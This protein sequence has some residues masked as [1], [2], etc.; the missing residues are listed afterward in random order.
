[1]GPWLRWLE[2]HKPLWDFLTAVGTVGLAAVT[3]WLAN[4]EAHKAQLSV[5]LRI[6]IGPGAKEPFPEY[7][8]FRIVNNG[9]LP[10]RITQI[11]WRWGLRKKLA[12]VQMYEPTLSSPLPANLGHGEEAQWFVPTQWRAEDPWPKYF[13]KALMPAYRISLRTLRAEAFSS[14]GKTFVAKPESSL[15]AKLRGA[16][17]DLAKRPRGISSANAASG[18]H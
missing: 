7:V 9:S 17:D 16:C 18:T 10:L 11:G 12:A 15:I 6:M 13:G 1:M 5:G 3:V 2:E 8:V 4:R 14:I